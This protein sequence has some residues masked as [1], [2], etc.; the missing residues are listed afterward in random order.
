MRL[1]LLPLIALL[2]FPGRAAHAQTDSLRTP[3]L[4]VKGRILMFAN[5]LGIEYFPARRHS[6]EVYGVA[7]YYSGTPSIDLT[8]EGALIAAYRYYLRPTFGEKRVRRWYLS[9]FLKHTRLAYGQGKLEDGDTY[10]PRGIRWC[11]GFVV[12]RQ[13]LSPTRSGLIE[14]FIGPQFGMSHDLERTYFSNGS[15][16]SH[17]GNRQFWTIRAG[18]DFG[19]VSYRKR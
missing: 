10:R 16:N 18:I 9:P 19:I 1:F 3:L 6:V 13:V 15:V 8:R 11:P 12:G 2:A 14:W 7:S 5:G 17:W 4:H